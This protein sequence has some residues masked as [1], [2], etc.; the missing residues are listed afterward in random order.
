VLPVAQS[1]GPLLASAAVPRTLEPLDRPM[2]AAPPHADLP[3]PRPRPR[4]PTDGCGRCG[5]HDLRRASGM[6]WWARVD[7][8]VERDALLHRLERLDD[9]LEELSRER[10]AIV[11]ALTDLREL[12]YPPIPWAKGRRP[13]DVDHAP[14]PPAT[15]GS[16]ALSGRDLRATC[17]SILRRHGVLSLV[18][19]HGLVHRYGYVIG[20]RR[21]VTALS[22]AM[23]YEVEQQRAR[24]VERGVYAAVDAPPR[25][26]HRPVTLP[27]EP[28]GVWISARP[29]APDPDLDED[30]DSWTIAGTDER[31]P[32]PG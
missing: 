5:T 23:A 14:I 32:P 27:R 25:R 21:P 8:Q 10:Q 16:T 4:R 31:S 28:H 9:E 19:L 20:S 22:D 18:E 1:P 2:T 29:S 6:S 13:P 30:P 15:E 24:R 3:P 12:L 7:L 17:L 11:A 26:R